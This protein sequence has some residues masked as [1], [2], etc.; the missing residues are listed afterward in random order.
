VR[1]RGGVPGGVP[2]APRNPKVCIG[3]ANVPSIYGHASKSLQASRL[4]MSSETFI[5][6]RHT[7]DRHTRDTYVTAPYTPVRHRPGGAG[8]RDT[9]D[10]HRTRGR[11]RAQGS[12]RRTSQPSKPTNTQP[13]RQRDDRSRSRGRQNSRRPGADRSRLHPLPVSQSVAAA[14]LAEDGSRRSR[15]GAVP[16]YC[17]T[18]DGRRMLYDVNRISFCPS[19]YWPTV[20]VASSRVGFSRRSSVSRRAMASGSRRGSDTSRSCSSA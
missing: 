17:F 12:H 18:V 5:S 13:A 20:A 19:R 3:S 7:R 1:H 14:H 2:G 6:I 10:T 16:D 11:T 4:T 9:Q 8:S 15:P